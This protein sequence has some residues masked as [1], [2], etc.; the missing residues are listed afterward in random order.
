MSSVLVRCCLF[1]YLADPAPLVAEEDRSIGAPSVAVAESEVGGALRAAVEAKQLHEAL[2]CLSDEKRCGRCET[3]VQTLVESLQSEDAEIRW[4]S[5]RLIGKLGRNAVAAVPNLLKMVDDD[6]PMVR[7][8]AADALAQI[9]PET[10]DGIDVLLTT[11]QGEDP[12]VRWTAIRAMSSVGPQ[13]R[14]AAPALVQLL[15][16]ENLMVRREAAR[17]LKIV[18]QHVTTV[19]AKTR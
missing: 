19:G 18:S 1:V 13:A 11:V 5:A 7:W 3:A 9:A 17:T 16:D 6:D 14:R 12:M 4:L 2:I 10:R 15:Q 8:S